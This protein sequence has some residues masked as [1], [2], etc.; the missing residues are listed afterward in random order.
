MSKATDKNTKAM[1]RLYLY[2]VLRSPHV[3]EKATIG[4]TE[5][6]YTFKVNP[7]ATKQDIKLAVEKLFKVKVTAV[8]TINLKGKEKRFRGRIGKR[9]DV[10]KAIVRLA[11]GQTIDMTA[12]L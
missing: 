10:R 1:S 3:T 7:T 2:D 8:N 11:E 6:R 9:D 4:T 12:G 5:N